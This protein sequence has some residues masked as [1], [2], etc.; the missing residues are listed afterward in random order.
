MKKLVRG[1]GTGFWEWL[2]E[3][4]IGFEK[5]DFGWLTADEPP[6]IKPVWDF[7]QYLSL[8]GRGEAIAYL[9]G[10]LGRTL[11]Y[12]GPVLDVDLLYGFNDHTDRHTLWVAQT[13]V[14][15]LL[16]S[17]TGWDG[18]RRTGTVDEL[19][20]ALLGMTHDLGNL[21]GRGRHAESTV[22]I[23]SQMFTNKGKRKGEWAAAM[24][25]IKFHDEGAIE[26]EGFDLE[27]GGPLLWAL[28]VADK[29]H[30]GRDR[31]GDKSIATGP[32]GS[33]EADVHVLLN[34]L[35]T[36]STWY[37]SQGSFVWH[38]D[39]SVEQ[40]TEKFAALTNRKERVWVPQKF[41]MSWRRAGVK[42]RESF[43]RDFVEVYHERIEL[44]CQAVLRL[45][46]QVEAV[47]IV[48]SDDDSKN[49][50]GRGDV[51][52]MKWERPR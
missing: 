24:E 31:V 23:L 2:R 10:G 32:N 22:E 13:G 25:A 38:L 20:M 29:L 44:L 51:E 45:F 14:E 35:V 48:L 17:G 47:R 5:T 7:N 50:V 39:F 40:L 30:V 34:S 1:D 16:R 43:A 28:I 12:V 42:Y 3:Q 15:L 37:L 9:Y 18:K 26:R 21:V 11:N 6:R 27:R 36:R 46:G 41:Q 8:R 52:I 19:L 33:V 4:E 49:K